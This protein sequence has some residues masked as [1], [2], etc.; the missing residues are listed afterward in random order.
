MTLK[1]R[2]LF[3]LMF[4]I[5][6]GCHTVSD[7]SNRNMV[8]LYRRDDLLFNPDFTAYLV[9]DSS[10]Q[11]F[12][13][14]NPDELL[15]VRQNDNSF[16]AGVKVHGELMRSFDDP[17]IID[18]LSA[19]LYFN[20]TEKS[21]KKTL[22]IQIPVREKGEFLLH[23]QLTDLNKGFHED[24]Y[25]NVDNSSA[26]SRNAFLVTDANDPLFRNYITTSDSFRLFYNDSNRTAVFCK[27]YKREFPLPPPPFGFN[28][29]EDFNYHPD[30]FFT[31]SVNEMQWIH[32]KADGFY[33]F[34]TDTSQR[35]GFTLYHYST[36]FPVITSAQQMIEPVRF[37]TSRK[38]FD[39][40]KA[41]GSAKAAV[42]E[43]WLVRGNRNE[44]KTRALIKKYYGRVQ[45]ANKLFTSYVEGWR[46][47]RG[48]IYTIFGSPNT[49]F[50][51][52]NSE[53]WIY[54]SANNPLSVNF[55]FMKVD[56]PFTDNDYLLSRAPVYES[57]WYR[58]VEIWRQG[59]PYNSFY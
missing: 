7:I 57:A 34:Q 49:V 38:E 47:D 24:F 9:N 39:D 1:K 26:D 19:D 13:R 44:E 30:S 11:L 12:T 59:R 4:L 14:M 52:A 58:A 17:K 6:Y 21:D 50:R 20:I 10:L 15:F 25:L 40:L 41:K 56:N 32:L 31:V 37:L 3:L 16:R 53:T 54:G 2:I 27:Y 18:S 5:V 46:T 55:F 29:H 33:H 8:Y 23:I 51:S 28:V 36:T 22:A 48:M 43:F 35:K 45:E 42:D